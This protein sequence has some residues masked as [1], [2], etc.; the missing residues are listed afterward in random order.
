MALG[1]VATLTLDHTQVGASDATDFPVVFRGAAAIKTVGNGGSYVQLTNGHDIQFFSDSA[2]TT[3]LDY[4]L[5]SWDPTT[6]IGEWWIR[7]PTLSHTSDTLI[8]I[9]VGD[10]G[11]SDRS[12]ATG[13]W[14]SQ[15]LGVWHLGDGSSVILT[16][17]TT[18]ANTAV[19]NVETG[20]PA[21]LSAVTGQIGG[22]VHNP[23][24]TD[25]NN[26]T[27]EVNSTLIGGLTA[28]TW[29]AWGKY[30]GAHGRNMFGI[31]DRATFSDFWEVGEG[32]GV[33]LR[34]GSDDFGGANAWDA[35]TWVKADVMLGG[36][37]D[38]IY[39][40]ASSIYST[41]NTSTINSA[42][43][44]FAFGSTYGGSGG[45]KT[46]F[47]GDIDEVRVVNTNLSA[48][49]LTA[50]YN[51][52]KDSQTLV[53]LGTF[54]AVGGS[55][56]TITPGLGAVAIDGIAPAVQLRVGVPVGAVAVAGLAPNIAGVT[57]TPGAGA[58]AIA[59]AAPGVQAS[60]GVP[61][62][63]VAVAGVSPSVQQAI[64]VP[65]GATAIA[66]VAP[67]I[68]NVTVTVPVGAATVLGQAPALQTRVGVP[69]GAVAVA[70]LAPS[71]AGLTITVPAGTLT[72][73]GVAAAAQLAVGAPAGAIAA[74]GIAAGLRTSVQTS[75]GAIAAA[76]LA[77]SISGVTINVPVGVL[78]AAGVAIATQ[79]ACGVPAGSFAAQGAAAGLLTDVRTSA[80]AVVL[81]GLPITLPSGVGIAVGA[82]AIAVAGVAPA[83]QSDV[84]VPAGLIAAAG[85]AVAAR[86]Q[87]GVPAGAV[88]TLGI[89]PTITIATPGSV[90]VTPATCALACAGRAP[91]VGTQ[92]LRD[93]EQT[94]QRVTAIAY[95]QRV[96]PIS[97]SEVLS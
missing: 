38:K 64:G 33:R 54:S 67:N 80:G 8:Y 25:F 47:S 69:A 41:A 20:S 62:G 28:F 59:G 14:S 77:P 40:N 17:S 11:A 87:I 95:S 26:R 56:T 44:K 18:H 79:T 10:S 58:V 57:I 72:A 52:Q 68:G 76:G 13:V 96:D 63:V 61:A 78:A 83:V 1:F 46:I 48:D 5:V 88:L 94:L 12:N 4:E 81:A 92:I 73:A 37:T 45:V 23:S 39:K 31:S 6:G 7:V 43:G 89:A 34:I 16:D 9:G 22:A 49:W 65:V 53:S 15:Y 75:T 74:D 19:S 21:A 91:V 55:G 82:G 42:T 2:L 32:G 27:I 30:S 97:Y 35:S 66:G 29:Q 85:V 3:I 93:F 24:D 51:N 36:G 90:T 84:R 86:A 70:G 50:E 60:A 71:I